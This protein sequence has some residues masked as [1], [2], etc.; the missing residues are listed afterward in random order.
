VVADL[1]IPVGDDQPNRRRLDDPSWVDEIVSGA[2]KKVATGGGDAPEV[3]AQPGPGGESAPKKVVR[4][5]IVKR[6]V[7]RPVDPEKV[8]EAAGDGA[9]GEPGI[10]AGGL[11]GSLMTATSPTMALPRID[12]G[13]H[14]DPP[15]TEVVEEDRRSWRSAVEW[16][17]VLVAALVVA[18]LVKT[19]LFQAFYI[20][21]ASMETTLNV[22]DRVLVNKVSYDL[23]EVNRGDLVVF[24]RPPGESGPGDEIDDLIKRTI[25]LPGETVEVRSS[26][27]YIDGL[28]LDEPYLDEE[29]VYPDFGP[30]T[31]PAQQ[32]FMMGDNRPDSRDSR[33]FGPIDTGQIVGRAF[34][35][36]WPPS[37]VGFL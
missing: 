27:V 12:S 15:E 28:A 11:P 31:V 33:V 32:I 13:G 1:D 34:F 14:D 21:S 35:R 8:P 7:K 37:S 22:G 29:L 2:V 25:A 19:F 20:P 36:I 30:I 23:H 17:L 26:V 10:S 5:R 3:A 9:D 16:G 24:K 6:P 4:K 18:I